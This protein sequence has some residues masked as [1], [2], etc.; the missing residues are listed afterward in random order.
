MV[1][2]FTLLGYST[3]GQCRVELLRL[4]SERFAGSNPVPRHQQYLGK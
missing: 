4:L 3:F 2:L 1:E